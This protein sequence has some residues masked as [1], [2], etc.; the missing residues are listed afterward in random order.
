M[1]LEISVLPSSLSSLR[2][3]NRDC[4]VVLVRMISTRAGAAESVIR[5]KARLSRVRLVP[6][7]RPWARAIAPSL[8]IR[9]QLRL[10]WVSGPHAAIRALK[11][12]QAGSPTRL[13][14]RFSSTTVHVGR[15][16][17][18]CHTV[19]GTTRVSMPFVN[20]VSSTFLKPSSSHFALNFATSSS[21]G[22][23]ISPQP[24]LTCIAFAMASTPALP[25]LFHERFSDRSLLFRSR[26]SPRASPPALPM[27]FCHRLR[28]PCS[29][30]F[31]KGFMWVHSAFTPSSLIR[32]WPSSK[33]RSWFFS[34]KVRASAAAPRWPMAFQLKS[35][36]LTSMLE[37]STNAKAIAV[38]S[39]RLLP[40]M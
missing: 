28:W 31:R 12:T 18:C 2:W 24:A 15:S 29:S 38:S 33:V 7:C 9:F 32:F 17:S 14:H 40:C 20:F 21:V 5:L 26:N 27:L 19:A 10:R 3:K 23:R 25:T 16:G 22:G 34:A 6:C 39:P 11:A 13:W 4:S 30:S 36:C 8:V 1:L 37:R 35:R